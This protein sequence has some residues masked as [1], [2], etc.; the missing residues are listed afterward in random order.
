M[1]AARGLIGAALVA[2]A[3]PVLAK[4]ETAQAFAALD[5][6][7]AAAA[8]DRAGARACVG[9]AA[10][11]CMDTTEGGQTT[12]GM[13]VCLMDELDWWD[14]RLS[15]TFTELMA[16]HAAMDAE[17][18]AAGLTLPSLAETLEDFHR[19]WS[20]YRDAACTYEHAHWMGGTG[21]GPASAACR[22]HLTGAHAL[23]LMARLGDARLP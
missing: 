3:T 13:G 22:L 11:V 23:D 5:A 19:A 21:G 7:L 16:L 4:D 9:R 2:L 17:N 20:A 12:V 1:I 18:A 14:A 8:D 10:G 15:E 6:C